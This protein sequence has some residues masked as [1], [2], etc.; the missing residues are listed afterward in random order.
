MDTVKLSEAFNN[1][2]MASKSLE[3]YYNL[4][5][6]RVRHLT[7]E[8]EQKNRELNIALEEVEKNR[9]Y[10]DAILYNLEEAIIVLDTDERVTLIN[11]AASTL[12]HSEPEALIGKPFSGLDFTVDEEGSDTILYAKGK[13]YS[14]IISHSKILDSTGFSKGSVILIKDITRLRELEMQQERNQR[15]IAMGEMAAKIVHEIRNP[16]CSIELFATMLE[17]EITEASLKELAKGIATGVSNLNNILTN[18]LFF[19]KPHR[20][21]KK[22]ANLREIIEE[23]LNMLSA[24]I[25]IRNVII[26]K[27]LFDGFISCD[28]ELLKQVMINLI[29]NALQAMPDGGII[30]ID[31]TD[32]ESQKGDLIIVDITDTGI[33]IKKEFLEKIFDPFFSTKDRGTGLGLTIASNIM[34][35]HGGFIKVRSEEGKGSTFSLH[36]PHHRDNL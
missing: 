13:R 20:P 24:L 33:G 19:A 3:T 9:D 35:S 26:E 36:F 7:T 5:Q 12:L 16:L 29:V 6:E 15:L 30:R 22:I 27:K 34:Q 25:E 28:T 2:T 10:L 17:K 11:K 1:F 4:L 31:M 32:S 14:V 21:S 23:S 18:M 8:L